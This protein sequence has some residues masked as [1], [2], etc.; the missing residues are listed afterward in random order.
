MNGFHIQLSIFMPT[1]KD[2]FAPGTYIVRRSIWQSELYQKGSSATDR[3]KWVTAMEAENPGP[4]WSYTYPCLAVLGL[5]TIAPWASWPPWT[6]KP[7]SHL[8]PDHCTGIG[9]VPAGPLCSE[10][11][12]RTNPTH[13]NS[14]RRSHSGPSARL[15]SLTPPWGTV[16]SP[17]GPD[18]NL[19]CDGAPQSK[20]QILAAP[21]Q[22]S[23]HPWISISAS[24]GWATWYLSCNVFARIINSR[25]DWSWLCEDQKIFLCLM[26]SAYSRHY[27]FMLSLFPIPFQWEL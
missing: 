26:H 13:D 16:K 20:G 2:L 6:G 15:S 23:E 27:V 8:H 7:Y 24:W 14:P 3:Q 9:G 18:L 17:G 22:V 10:P 4:A 12:T 5:H 11:S 19:C 25:E 21:S 1:T